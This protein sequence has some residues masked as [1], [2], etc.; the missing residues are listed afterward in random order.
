[1][2]LSLAITAIILSTISIAAAFYATTQVEAFKRST[3]KVMFYDTA[4]QQFQALTDQEK[5]Q[6]TKPPFDNIN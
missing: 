5:E 2:I 1:M 4:N 6:L 3:H